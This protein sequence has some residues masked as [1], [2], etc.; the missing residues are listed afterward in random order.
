MF[1]QFIDCGLIQRAKKRRAKKLSH[2]RNLWWMTNEVYNWMC[3]EVQD[4]PLPI[5]SDN[6]Q[7]QMKFY[8][9]YVRFGNKSV[10]RH[11]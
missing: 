2:D 5:T 7:G 9:S 3:R 8:R 11:L 4:A 1:E 6:Y 10:E